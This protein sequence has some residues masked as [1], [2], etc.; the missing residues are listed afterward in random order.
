MRCLVLHQPWASAC[1]VFKW[2]ETRSWPAPATIVGKRVAIAA[3]VTRDGW[4]YAGADMLAVSASWHIKPA[5]APHGAVVCTA[6]IKSCR[7]TE[8]YGS[9]DPQ[10]RTAGDWTP[11]RFAWALDDI[12]RLQ[13]P[14]PIRGMQGVFRIPQDVFDRIVI[15]GGAMGSSVDE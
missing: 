10:N 8:S 5:T 1:G 4:R 13:V 2:H 6:V 14:V 15:Q 7:P 3:A 11:T 9:V 12:V